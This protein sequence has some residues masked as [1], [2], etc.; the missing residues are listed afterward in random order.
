VLVKEIWPEVLSIPLQ[1]VGTGTF[2]I[3]TIVGGNSTQ[4][5][6]FFFKENVQMV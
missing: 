3:Q 1:Y 2:G 6:T 5:F 4:P